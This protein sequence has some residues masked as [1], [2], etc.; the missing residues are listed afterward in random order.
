[1]GGRGASSGISDKG[2]KYGTEYH[3]VLKVANV[4]FIVQNAKGSVKTPMETMTHGRVYVTIGGNG[5]PKSIT[6][7]DSN[8]KR[9]KQIDIT[10]TPHKINGKYVLPHTHY[11]YIHDENG[12]TELSARDRK[13]VERLVRYWYNHRGKE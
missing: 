5:A 12:T 1:M 11:G 9:Y 13:R 4:K 10:G 8:N 6:F 3:S 7:Y 2:K